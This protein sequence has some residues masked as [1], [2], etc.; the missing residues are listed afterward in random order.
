MGLAATDESEARHGAHRAGLEAVQLRHTS[1]L[2]RE[3]YVK[4]EAWKSASLE[5]CPWHPE[6]GCGIA[7]HTP[8]P[9]VEPPGMKVAR[10]YC[11]KAHATVSLL[12]DFLASRLSST[13]AA[14]EKVVATVE[15]RE[16]SIEAV[17]EELR[18][19]V[20]GQ[21]AVRWVMR[22][23]AAVAAVLKALKGLRPD[24]FAKVAP[25]LDAFRAAL[26]ASTVLPA[27]RAMAGAQLPFVPPPVGFGHRHQRRKTG[28]ERRQ[29]EAGADPP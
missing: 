28:R 17:A 2:T 13:L 6:G 22:R 26:S 29:H 12:P 19:D 1:Q 16:A 14:V 11:E 21:G 8:Y 23:V 24:V 10:W 9:R 3:D 5:K 20:G 18:P 4:Q 7:K 25:T 15:Q 27:L